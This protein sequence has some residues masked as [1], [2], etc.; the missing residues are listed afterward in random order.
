[1]AALVIG[2]RGQ[3]MG[4]AFRTRFGGSVDECTRNRVRRGSMEFQCSTWLWQ[5][6]CHCRP[7][8][9]SDGLLGGRGSPPTPKLIFVSQGIDDIAVRGRRAPPK[10]IQTATV[11]WR[12][13]IGFYYH[14]RVKV[15]G[16][17]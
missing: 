1:M 6:E 2:R 8:R 7:G 13:V 11:C 15:A 4:I 10:E 14:Y 17:N 9:Q 3:S 12:Q 5:I 16:L